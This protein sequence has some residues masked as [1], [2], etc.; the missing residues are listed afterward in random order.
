MM[1][2]GEMF[3]SLSDFIDEE[4]SEETC[5][6]IRKHLQDCHNCQVVVNTLKHT[7]SLYHTFPQEEVPGEVRRRLHKIIRMEGDKS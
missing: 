7:V 6:E 1:D 2:C 4:I 3:E 5:A